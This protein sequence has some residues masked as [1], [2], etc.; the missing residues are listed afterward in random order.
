MHSAR[1]LALAFGLVSAMAYDDASAQTFQ[2]PVT[3]AANVGGGASLSN[4]HMLMSGNGSGTNGPASA[5]YGQN[6]SCAKTNWKTA[7]TVGEID[8]LNIGL[9]QGGP[10]SDGSGILVGVQ[11]T[12]LGTVTDMELTASNLNVATNTVPLMV[13]VQMGVINV[14]KQMYGTIINAVNGTGGV[15]VLVNALGNS[16]WSDVLEGAALGQ[17]YFRIDNSG[18]ITTKGRISTASLTTSGAIHAM[19]GVVTA[20]PASYSISAENCGTTIRSTDTA[21][22]RLAVPAG[23]PVGC[24]V[25]IIQASDAPITFQARGTQG[26]HVGAPDPRSFQTQGR[27][28]EAEL[29]IDSPRTFLLRG[30]VGSSHA[31]V[32]AYV[33]DRQPVHLSARLASIR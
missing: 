23:L 32:P 1:F 27:F 4:L 9:H 15:A 6:L 30:D 16:V 28:A 11:N 2:T 24:H 20:V 25:N 8:C 7:Q 22:V 3:I 17:I 14:N 10:G 18:N 12:G 5:Q 29:V 33:A 21:P 19:A 26:E 13:D 31:K